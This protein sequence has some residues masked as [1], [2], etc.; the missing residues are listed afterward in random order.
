VGEQH[1][2]RDGAG[3]AEH[4]V[5]TVAEASFDSDFGFEEVAANEVEYGTCE[6]GTGVLL[7]RAVE[8]GGCDRWQGRE[9]AVC[10]VLHR[11][12]TDYG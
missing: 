6:F 9:E 8:C 10:E 2:A 5:L 11:S 7:R 3:V 12:G 1:P 4:A